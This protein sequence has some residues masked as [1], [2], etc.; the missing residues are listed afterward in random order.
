MLD[1]LREHWERDGDPDRLHLERFQPDDRRRRARARAARSGSSTSEH[2][3]RVRRRHA[4]PRRRRGGR[5][6]AAVRL[7]RGHLP[8]LRREAVLRAGARPAQRR[9]ARAPRARWSAPASTPPRAPS[10]SSY[11]RP[12]TPM[13]H[14][15][16][17]EPARAPDAPSRSRSSARS[18]TRSTTRSTTTSATA[19][20][21][22]PS[23]IEMHR[24]LAVL[25]A[26]SCSRRAT[27]PRGSRAPR[28]SRW[29]RSSRTWRSATTSCT[30]SGT[31]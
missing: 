2:G 30:A 10:R 20:A 6:R 26:C 21:V 24:R 23:M 13:S 27:S 3:G 12:E 25:A 17:R 22:H 18:S 16:D 28:R 15:T 9:G 1:A 5:R 8:H 29:R 4:D 14:R 31:G 11:D 19:T 7:P